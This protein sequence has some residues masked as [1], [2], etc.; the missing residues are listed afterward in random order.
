[1]KIVKYTLALMLCAT[2]A[3]NAQEAEEQATGLE[4]S[5]FNVQVGAIGAW[6]SHEARLSDKF[7]LRTEIGAEM[8]F[9]ETWQ[10]GDGTFFAPSINFEPRWYYNI[11]KRAAKGKHVENNSA[12][13]V[14][15]GFEYFPDLF[16]IGDVPSYIYVPNQL[17]II[18][19]WGIRRAIAKSDFHYELG[20]GLGVM[21]YLSDDNNWLTQD[22]G[23]AA[24]IHVRLGYT[25]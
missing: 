18:P 11:T 5:M 21:T 12:S 7:A 23:L 2:M 4:K 13:F 22:S 1:M 25:F 10:D 9:Y 14:T 20:F 24:D 16:T 8:W 3:G 19:K 17:S 6:G 15:I